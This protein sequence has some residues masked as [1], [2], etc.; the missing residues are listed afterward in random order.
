MK[1]QRALLEGKPNAFFSVNLVARKPHRNQ[2]DTNP[3]MR[4]FLR[5]LGFRPALMAVFAGKLSYPDY[6]PV[7][8]GIIR[9]IMALTGGPTDP[10]AV[11][12]FTDW[13]QVEAFAES[14]AKLDRSAVA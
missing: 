3:Y 8:R 5:R 10:R 6:G 7:D 12:E 11:V 2:P 4:K 1:K 9:M 13:A 14:L